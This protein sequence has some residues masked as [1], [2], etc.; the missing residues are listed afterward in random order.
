VAG[1]GDV[2]TDGYADVIAGAPDDDSAGSQAGAAFVLGLHASEAPGIAS[3]FGHA[4]CPCGNQD[5]DAGCANSTGSGALLRSHGSNQLDR[6]DLSFTASEL[7]AHQPA[8]LITGS[9]STPPVVLGDGMRCIGGSLVRLEVASSSGSGTASYGPGLAATLGASPGD[10][11]H[12][13]V[14]YRDPVGVCGT[15]FNAS[16]GLSIVFLD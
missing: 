14:W 2:D 4:A 6:D 9:V 11:L 15:G 5:V 8:L 7:P 16:S 10:T 3:C 1:A 13:Q 12:F